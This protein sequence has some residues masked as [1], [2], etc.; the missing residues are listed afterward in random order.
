MLRFIY[1]VFM[2]VILGI[3]GW[4]MF[5]VVGG[6]MGAPWLGWL[7]PVFVVGILVYSFM[8]ARNRPG[9]HADPSDDGVVG[10]LDTGRAQFDII[11]SPPPP[12]PYREIKNL[13]E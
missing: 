8:A 9:Y 2:S 12:P 4:I 5:T 3:V 10:I 11:P 7:F 6:A 13:D 1:S